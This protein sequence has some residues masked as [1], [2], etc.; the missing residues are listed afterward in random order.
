MGSRTP[1]PKTIIWVIGLSK[2]KSEISMQLAQWI[3]KKENTK[4]FQ[5][6][7]NMCTKTNAIEIFRISLCT[8]N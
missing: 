8:K 3:T 2:V 6:L 1:G 4:A 7:V 5:N